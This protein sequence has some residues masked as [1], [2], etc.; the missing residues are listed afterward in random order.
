MF[1][2]CVCDVCALCVCPVCVM[3]VCF[4]IVHALSPVS[5][6]V[7]SFC[8]RAHSVLSAL[9]SSLF[10]QGPSKY[11]ELLSAGVDRFTRQNN[12]EKIATFSLL[13][14]FDSLNAA[15][16]RVITLA[17]P[18]SLLPY[19]PPHLM[20][21]WRL[22]Q[23]AVYYNLMLNRHILTLAELRILQDSAD[24]LVDQV[25]Q[26]Y[27]PGFITFN[28]H[29]DAHDAR[30]I[31]RHGAM[32]NYSCM[33]DEST[34]GLVKRIGVRNTNNT[35]VPWSIVSS[36]WLSKCLS[37]MFDPLREIN[38]GE[39]HNT[40][41]GSML[42][43]DDPQLTN[44][45]SSCLA[46]PAHEAANRHMFFSSTITVS[47][48]KY[49]VGDFIH[50][51]SIGGDVLLRI[52]HLHSVTT[53]QHL[54]ISLARCTVFSY[55]HDDPDSGFAV[56]Q[57]SANQSPCCVRLNSMCSLFFVLDTTPDQVSVLGQRF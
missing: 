17:A 37:L 56:Y 18:M 32:S 26:L 24:E 48:V 43:G 31:L 35:N 19:T 15:S 49:N 8:L 6:C 54:P 55:V 20:S 50:H 10:N 38:K 4:C 51:G 36:I 30:C 9:I 5:V 28:L 53:A 21:S 33:V 25:A 23:K 29:D 3:C 45:V 16:K 22:L 1:V 7:S 34:V 42:C 57:K 14:E 13:S 46:I 47:H 52:D 41:G 12:I 39:Y 27:E 2:L 11:W 44:M 40:C